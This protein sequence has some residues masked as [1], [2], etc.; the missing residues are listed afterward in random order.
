MAKTSKPIKK[1]TLKKFNGNF[2]NDPDLI[3]FW[4]NSTDMYPKAKK[5]RKKK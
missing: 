2:S 5:K 3:D 4:T 1:I